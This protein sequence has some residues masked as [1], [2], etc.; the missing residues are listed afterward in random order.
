MGLS[1]SFQIFFFFSFLNETYA[2][3]HGLQKIVLMVAVTFLFGEREHIREGK[4]RKKRKKEKEK[5]VELTKLEKLLDALPN[6]LLLFWDPQMV[7]R[8]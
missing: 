4:K 5:Q 2:I 8:F 1:L 7:R 3:H 6:P